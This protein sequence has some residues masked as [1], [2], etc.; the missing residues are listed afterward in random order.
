MKFTVC[1]I[2]IAIE[3]FANGCSAKT[4]IQPLFECT[5][6][7]ENPYGIV[8]HISRSGSQ[9]EYDM[10]DQAIHSLEDLGVNCV[11]TDLDCGGITPVG[12]PTTV[13]RFDNLLSRTSNSGFNVC[14]I[15]TDLKNNLRCWDD[16]PSY[17]RY[18][19]TLLSRYDKYL[20]AYEILNE[21]DRIPDDKLTE[22]YNNLLKQTYS[23]IKEKNPDAQVLYSGIS[24]SKAGLFNLSMKDGAF[25]YF[26]IM[27]LHAYDIPE[28]LISHFDDIKKNMEKYGW[29]KHVWLTET[30]YSSCSESPVKDIFIATEEE[31]AFRL[32][33]LFLIAFSCGVD[34]VFWYS[35]RSAELTASEKEYFFG[36]THA[37]FCPKP[38][39]K[40]YKTLIKMCP[41]GSSRPRMKIIDDYYFVRWET[42]DN[43]YIA[44]LWLSENSK[45]TEHPDLS[46]KCFDMY[47]NK[48]SHHD[49]KRKLSMKEVIYIVL[50]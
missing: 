8:S 19:D 36:I 22:K 6:N 20:T 26:D 28:N 5:K 41:N 21:A 39:F 35:H 15:L 30:G 18:I 25:D 23:R 40:T 46:G 24:W 43:K 7:L 47:G 10:L 9:Y 45:S 49:A 2:I 31:Q 42:P 4:E 44:A 50:K 48:I 33:K 27:N 32:P 37:D 13:T 38:A 11:R 34:K 29:S 3:V 1:S 12:A 16:Y 14:G 17:W